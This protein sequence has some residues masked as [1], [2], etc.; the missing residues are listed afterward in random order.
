MVSHDSVEL[1]PRDG[2]FQDAVA[3]GEYFNP[4]NIAY[5]PIE[6]APVRRR[7][8]PPGART[9]LEQPLLLDDSVV[10]RQASIDVG[11]GD[12]DDRRRSNSKPKDDYIMS[13]E[14]YCSSGL[15]SDAKENPFDSQGVPKPITHRSL[16]RYLQGWLVH[17][18]ALAS[19]AVIIWISLE[20]WYWFPESGP[21]PEQGIS[22]DVINNLLQFAAKIHE[23]L[24][25]ASLSSIAISMV[26]R[27]LVGD[28]VR[29]GF[30]T[31]GYRVGDLNYLAS[32]PFRHQGM[33]QL[34]SWEFI[35]VAYLFF[36]TLMSTIVGPAS[37]VLLVP[38][39]GWFPMDHDKA[40][41]KINM[42][43][44]YDSTAGQVWPTV[45]NDTLEWQDIS[46]CL[47]TEGTYQS[48]C[49]SGGFSEIWNWAQS[50]GATN[51]QNNL[52]FQFPSTDL[53]RH[54]V[55]TEAENTQ[56]TVLST[57]PSNF[58]MISFGL[59][60]KYIDRTDV[61]LVH[62]SPRYHLKARLVNR[63]DSE[64]REKD[65]PIYQPFVQSSCKVYRETVVLSTKE[66]MVYPTDALSCFDDGECQTLKGNPPPFD[67]TWWNDKTRDKDYISTRFFPYGNQSSS[68]VLIAGQVPDNTDRAKDLIYTCSLFASWVPSEFSLDPKAS[69][70]LYSSLNGE[71]EMRSVFKAH[72]DNARVIRFDDS[73][74]KYLDPEF[75][76]ST[77]RNPTTAV[78]QLVDLFSGLASNATKDSVVPLTKREDDEAESFLSKLFGVYLT[79]G[80]A[81]TGTPAS[82]MIKLEGDATSMK[83]VDLNALY[84]ATGGNFSV[85]TMNETHTEWNFDKTPLPRPITMD[86]IN[87]E[88][89]PSLLNFDFDVERYGYGTGRPRKTLTFAQVM[90][91]IYL[92]TVVLYAL[93]VGLAHAIEL[94]GRGRKLRL[95]SVVPWSDLQD[96]IILALKTPAPRD[97]DLADA[98]AGVTSPDVWKKTVRAR[99]RDQH[100]QLVLNDET[101]TERLDITGKEKYY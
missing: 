31:G 81:R 7:P 18:P 19:T 41:S 34:V 9:T 15:E 35:L 22:A 83:G 67:R 39:P 71:T 52:T 11:A 99:A 75:N 87:N 21:F 65:Q 42:P 59:V 72:P 29:L 68:V 17:I 78:L 16:R 24:I 30:L 56:K 23:L 3:S 47:Y 100:V 10:H 32:S 101:S 64:N 45:F 80:I 12:L 40:F 69:D 48:W 95:L 82:T 51:L 14:P 92:G 58:F 13:V 27:R 86:D 96:L 37:A 1:S 28:G 26:R 66:K 46:E 77:R 2:A 5:D 54:L 49:P 89:L 61:G 63:T 55:H 93:T 73:W 84:G 88:L 91:Y 57:T 97:A 4:N 38:T 90:M 36:A 94:T 44:F 6:P 79:E 62:G 70:V 76:T 25:V 50:F 98:G 8:L 74:F 85:Q 20:K 53:R 43:I 60:Q 33:K